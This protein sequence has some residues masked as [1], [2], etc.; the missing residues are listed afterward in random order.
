MNDRACIRRCCFR[1]MKKSIFVDGALKTPSEEMWRVWR[2]AAGYKLHPSFSCFLFFFIQTPKATANR[3][4]PA[5]FA[6]ETTRIE[7]NRTV[8]MFP[9]ELFTSSST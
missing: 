8:L 4:C 3:L 2:A 6:Q 9:L 5:V 1:L 7:P